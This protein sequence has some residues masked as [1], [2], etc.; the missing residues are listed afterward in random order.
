MHGPINI[1]LL[2]GICA[3]LGCNVGCRSN[4]LPIGFHETSARN[5][6]YTPL[7][8]TEERRSHLYRSR[9]LSL[10]RIYI[11]DDSHFTSRFRS[12]GG[13]SPFSKPFWCVIKRRCSHWHNRIRH[14][15]VPFRR[16][17]WARLFEVTERVRT[18]LYLLGS[19]NVNSHTFP[20]LHCRLFLSSDMGEKLVEL[21]RECGELYGLSN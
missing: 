20:P 9:S 2:S 10:T 11:W 21:V 16:R 1:R 17:C 15:S 8:I 13:T 6:P 19:D 5:Y 7:N 14:I 3:I 4:Y 12:V 18:C